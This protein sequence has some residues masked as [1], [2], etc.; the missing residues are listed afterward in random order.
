M[1]KSINN[2]INSIT[3][4]EKEYKFLS[5]ITIKRKTSNR[6]LKFSEIK[7]EIIAKIKR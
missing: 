2:S 1:I 3:L 5:E 7:E 4:L 6:N